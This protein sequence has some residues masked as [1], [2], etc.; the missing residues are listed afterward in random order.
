MLKSSVLYP[1]PNQLLILLIR[2]QVARYRFDSVIGPETTQQ[3]LF[4]TEI[5]PFVI[6]AMTGRNA[7]VFC[8]GATGAGKTYTMQGPGGDSG[9]AGIIPRAVCPLSCASAVL[10]T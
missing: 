7:S 4:D 10:K 6:D 5:E 3:E 9:G 1:L 2:L 8:Y